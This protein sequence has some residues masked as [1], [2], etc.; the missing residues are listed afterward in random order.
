[1]H[2][3]SVLEVSEHTLISKPLMA[4]VCLKYIGFGIL[5]TIKTALLVMA[6]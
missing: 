2:N 3:D 4:S 6:N 5:T 1:M